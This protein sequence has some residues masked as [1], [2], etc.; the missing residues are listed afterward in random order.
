MEDLRIYQSVCKKYYTELSILQFGKTGAED[1]V[2][3]L[4]TKTDKMKGI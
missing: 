1:N 3:T 2:S 4:N